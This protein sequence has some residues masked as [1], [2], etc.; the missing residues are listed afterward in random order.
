MQSPPT[1]GF[2]FGRFQVSAYGSP[3]GTGCYIIDTMTGR[4]WRVREGEPPELA[5]ELPQ[6]DSMPPTPNYE[7]IVP[8]TLPMPAPK[9]QLSPDPALESRQCRRAS[10]D[11]GVE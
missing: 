11:A 10:A 6:T 8:S 5:G 7:P 2:L 4:T 9:L 3:S 1:V